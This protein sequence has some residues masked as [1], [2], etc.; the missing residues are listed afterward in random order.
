MNKMNKPIMIGDTFSQ[1]R[2]ED[3]QE[4]YRKI[5]TTGY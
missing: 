5:G 2:T 4:A 3:L 1:K